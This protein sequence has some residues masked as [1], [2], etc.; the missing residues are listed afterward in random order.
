MPKKDA[1][2][3]IKSLPGVGAATAQK[4]VDG[5][6]TTVAKIAKA[7]AKELQNVGLSAGVATK[8]LAAAKTASKAKTVAK[9][10]GSATKSTA[11][12]AATKAASVAKEA[13]QKAVSKGQEVAEE[14]VEKTSSA[15]T[16]L[17][18]KKS[19][20]RKGDTINVPRSVKDMPWFKKR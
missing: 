1:S 6:Y 20:S 8:V 10:A 2:A 13:T 3:E 12:K 15:A 17:K 11:K 16:S 18:T 5:K 7:S 4:L 19:D 9:K 14:V